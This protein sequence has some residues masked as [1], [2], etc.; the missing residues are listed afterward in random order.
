LPQQYTYSTILATDTVAAT[1]IVK[2][3]IVYTTSLF[4]N[5]TLT[6]S[7]PKSDI[8]YTKYDYGIA[9]LLF[10][11]FVLF[12]WLYTANGKR[13]NQMIKA[14]YLNRYA[15]QLAREEFS[16][17]NRVSIFLFTLFVI[18]SSLFIS[19]IGYYF[20]FFVGG[21]RLLLFIAIA[22]AILIAY[23]LKIMSSNLLGFI[24]K[25]QKESS[26]YA[27]AIFLFCNTLGLFLLPVVV[28][29]AFVRQITPL[30]FIYLG[31]FI[32]ASF[33]AI[34]LLRGIIIGFNSVRVSKFYLFVYLC[35]LEIVPFVILVKLFILNSK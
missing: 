6:T 10:F 35:T 30:T 4:Q 17:G 29:I 21:N 3:D 14:F 19:Q 9:A 27:T 13:L 34:R 16:L 18:T 33:L 11:A 22:V 12:V 1:P 24:F 28:S 31:S 32:F 5:H 8:H 7:S 15:N 23:G 26:E 20:G 2:A 25:S